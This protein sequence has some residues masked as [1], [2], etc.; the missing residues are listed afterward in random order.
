[1]NDFRRSGARKVEFA[2]TVFWGY[3]T[4]PDAP[5]VGEGL[6]EEQAAP[7]PAPGEVI[8]RVGH[9]TEVTCLRAKLGG[10]QQ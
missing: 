9:N 6:D 3:G 2:H 4:E 5:P 8:A 7:E 10:I 1:M